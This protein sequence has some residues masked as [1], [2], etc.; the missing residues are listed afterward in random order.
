MSSLSLNN[1]SHYASWLGSLIISIICLIDF[2]K[3][4]GYV[5]VL[6]IYGLNSVL[7]SLLQELSSLLFQNQH[8]NTIGHIYVLLESIILSWLFYLVLPV[9]RFR[10]AIL[11]SIVLYILVFIF[12]F[13]LSPKSAHAIIRSVRDLQLII[14]CLGYFFYLLRELPQDDLIQFPMFWISTAL[15]IFFSGTFVLSYFREYIIAMMGDGFGNY[16]TF[17]NFFRFA[18]CLVLAYASWLN[19][20]SIRAQKSGLLH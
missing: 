13:S 11:I 3:R 14:F 17:R 12:A 16:W 5:K 7:F 20:Q 1:I 2:K 19:L 6:G 18:F 10:Q 9:R 15:L 4:P 8:I